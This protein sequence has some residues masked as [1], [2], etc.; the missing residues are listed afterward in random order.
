MKISSSSYEYIDLEDE[1]IQ[2]MITYYHN[3]IR[4]ET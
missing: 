1:H 3:Q 4:C 2:M